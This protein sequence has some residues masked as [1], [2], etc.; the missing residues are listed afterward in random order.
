MTTA[1][2]FNFIHT[3]HSLSTRDLFFGPLSGEVFTVF[4]DTWTLA[5]VL[6]ASGLFKSLTEARKNNGAGPIL[7]GWT[8]L[9][10]GKMKR[11]IYILN[12]FPGDDK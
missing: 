8:H 11:Q 5:H 4:D 1:N 7:P 2:E 3:Y 6:V 12:R 9:T 10:R